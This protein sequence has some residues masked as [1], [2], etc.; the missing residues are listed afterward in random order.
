MKT[1]ELTAVLVLS[2]LA[3]SAGIS[4]EGAV[5]ASA[6][7]EDNTAPAGTSITPRHVELQS[8][9]GTPQVEIF[10]YPTVG[11]ALGS[12]HINGNRT[13]IMLGMQNLPRVT[14]WTTAESWKPFDY[15][16]WPFMVTS[17]SPGFK[18][19]LG[20]PNPGV[21]FGPDFAN[22]VG[23]R[24]VWGTAAFSRNGIP[25]LAKNLYFSIVC[26][27]P[28]II[29]SLSGNLVNFGTSTEI[30]YSSTMIGKDYG[31]GGNPIIYEA[32]QSPETPVKDYFYFGPRTS[33]NAGSQSDLEADRNSATLPHFTLTYTVW[34]SPDGGTT[35]SAAKSITL[36]TDPKLVISR[37][38]GLM[39]LGQPN[40]LYRIQ[41]TT[42][43]GSSSWSLFRDNVKEGDWTI[44]RVAQNPPPHRFFRVILP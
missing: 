3:L 10:L 16:K 21:D 43:I 8:A 32:G 15:L 40:L 25:L 29:P 27:H 5:G 37:D 9:S 28:E 26:S 44:A 42:S 14:D 22:E 6:N 12:P 19:W 38:R 2:L 24:I 31:A 36:F 23:N 13:A 35:K 33:F 11:V 41:D 30:K 17:S 20:S 39:I 18:L 4:T 1:S 7:G 34:Y